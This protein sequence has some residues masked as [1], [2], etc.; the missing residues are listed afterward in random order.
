MND[1]TNLSRLPQPQVTVTIPPAVHVIDP[2]DAVRDSLDLL[3]EGAGFRVA[4]HRSTDDFLRASRGDPHACLVV[5]AGRSPHDGVPFLEAL[6]Q[7]RIEAPVI[8]L[9]DRVSPEE[10]A[11][12]HRMGADLVLAKPVHPAVVLHSVRRC[13]AQASA[14]RNALAA[15]SDMRFLPDALTPRERQVL[16]MA[17]SGEPNKIIGRKLG[18]SHRTVELHRSNILRKTGTANMLQLSSAFGVRALLDG[19]LTELGDASAEHA[20]A[21]GAQLS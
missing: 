6:R 11:Q 10:R 19:P 21:M 17:L 16:R 15:S 20:F 13:L 9:A 18:I 2:D 3:L 12:M 5:D 8:L 7:R 4:C 14:T 1:L